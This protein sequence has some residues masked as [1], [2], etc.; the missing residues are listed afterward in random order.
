ME[1]LLIYLNRFP[2]ISSFLSF[3]DNH[4]GIATYGVLAICCLMWLRVMK[5]L[6][7]NK[8]LVMWRRSTY[9][10]L[11]LIFAGTSNI[12]IS[13][14][15][16][17]LF[18]R[19]FMRIFVVESHAPDQPLSMP[20]QHLSDSSSPSYSYSPKAVAGAVRPWRVRTLIVLP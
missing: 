19:I 11:A 18:Y 16:T 3:L 17:Y 1:S 15:L 10:S 4:T 7:R 9:L 20:Y 6:G 12:L 8:N 2:A 5:W 14:V 13:T